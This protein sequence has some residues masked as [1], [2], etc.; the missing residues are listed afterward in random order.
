VTFFADAA[1]P[2]GAHF[3]V[4]TLVPAPAAAAELVLDRHWLTAA[5][6]GEPIVATAPNAH[7]DV[8]RLIREGS[9]RVIWGERLLDTTP[10][11]LEASFQF[12]VPADL[13]IPGLVEAGLWDAERNRA[14]GWSARIA[15]VIP[16]AAELFEVDD[17]GR[18]LTAYE[19]SDTGDGGMI[20]TFDLASGRLIDQIPVQA[21]QRVLALTPD[22]DYAWV[23][24]NVARG[25]LA[26]LDLRSRDVDLPVTLSVG[27]AP[28][29]EIKAQ[30]DRRDPRLWLVSATSS[31]F[32]TLLAAY[33]GNTLL[34]SP[35]RPGTIPIQTDDR[36]RYL[37]NQREACVLDPDIGLSEC[38]VL[39]SSTRLT[40][41]ALWG[42][43]A[44]A[45]G[46][47]FDLSMRS[48]SPR[49]AGSAISTGTGAIVLK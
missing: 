39:T 6:G 14:L 32:Q 12:T 31:T 4:T 7:P 40:V 3:L 10:V 27:T 2:L 28:Y 23:A 26:R 47:V 22:L 34:P 16:T 48:E 36:G 45:G 38:I 21:G 8:F 20:L 41:S 1:R 13:A 9:V 17:R 43:F 37:V 29:R 11:G 25:H 44:F 24:E 33:A 30:V 18:W 49:L 5:G 19:P 35:A 46:E 42:R 15:V